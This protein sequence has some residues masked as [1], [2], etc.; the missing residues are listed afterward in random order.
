MKGGA[1]R[2]RGCL[3][4][5]IGVVGLLV[6]CCVLGYFVAL[7]RVQDSIR[8]ELGNGITTQVAQQIDA[9]LPSGANLSPG[10]Y[11]IALSD[12]EQHVTDG[13]T[14]SQIDSLNV[15]GE[16]SEIV[17]SINASG[18]TVE[19]RGVPTVNANGE[20]EMTQMTST[21]VALDYVLPPDKLGQ[22][23]SAGVNT[24]VQ[25]QGLK[26][27]GVRLDG[28]ELVFDVVN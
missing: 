23:I 17:L 3:G 16:G 12:L 13:S 7:P 6:L 19:Y 22:A 20:L 11:R 28:N 21:G 10:E 4:G 9:Q 15:T 1:M 25:T 26:L 18:Q 2:R 14:A 24:Y 5:F 8:D 27:Q